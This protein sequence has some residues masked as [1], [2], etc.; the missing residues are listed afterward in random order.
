[1]TMATPM[2]TSVRKRTRTMKRT[3]K[4]TLMIMGTNLMP[5]PQVALQGLHSPT[6]KLNI[7]TNV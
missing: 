7:K 3:L 2:M 5:S 1:M 4:R 6:R